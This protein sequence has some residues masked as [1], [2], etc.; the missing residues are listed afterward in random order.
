M[1]KKYYKLWVDGEEF[2]DYDNKSDAIEKA[3]AFEENGADVE[4]QELDYIDFIAYERINDDS[5]DM[6]FDGLETQIIAKFQVK[7]SKIEELYDSGDY[8]DWFFETVK[9]FGHNYEDDAI[10]ELFAQDYF[11]G[12]VLNDGY[13]NKY[14]TFITIDGTNGAEEKIKEEIQKNKKYIKEQGEWDKYRQYF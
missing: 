11:M 3:K 9:Q 5:D 14:P 8:Y 13:E 10:S 4:V 6:T 1:S 2:G 12:V 7:E